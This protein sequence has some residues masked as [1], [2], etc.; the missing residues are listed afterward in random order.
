MKWNSTQLIELRL[1]EDGDDTFVNHGVND[2][3]NSEYSSNDGTNLNDKV[4]KAFF[5]LQK[6]DCN[7]TYIVSEKNCWE[8]ASLQIIIIGGELIDMG[9]MSI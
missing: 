6:S 4:E 8:V 5:L 9:L 3:C 2:A 7:R 1:F